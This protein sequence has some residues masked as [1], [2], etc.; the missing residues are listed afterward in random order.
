VALALTLSV[1]LAACTRMP[2]KNAGT[3][4]IVAPF[5]LGEYEQTCGIVSEQGDIVL[6][7][8]EGRIEHFNTDGEATFFDRKSGK[9]GVLDYRG[10][11]I[12]PPS[13]GNSGWKSRAQRAREA[14]AKKQQ[15]PDP[16]LPVDLVIVK[17]TPV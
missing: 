9:Y 5:C 15:A 7:P 2:G 10:K 14:E 8:R 3:P 11:I 16:F 4:P 13:L 1:S 12:V 6:A 17:P